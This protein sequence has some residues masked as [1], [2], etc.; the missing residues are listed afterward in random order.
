M[1]VGEEVMP[2]SCITF[3]LDL[4]PTSEVSNR[5]PGMMGH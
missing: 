4:S 2:E 3:Q 1:C 5:L